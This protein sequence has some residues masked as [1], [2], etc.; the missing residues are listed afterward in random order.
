MPPTHS[1]QAD[2]AAAYRTLIAHETEPK[3]QDFYRTRL[4]RLEPRTEPESDDF[5]TQLDAEFI[6]HARTAVPALVAAVERVQALADDLESRA[7]AIE[8]ANPTHTTQI[9]LHRQHAAM[10]RQALETKP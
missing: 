9:A 7:D 8:E 3:E 6:A 2:V 1:S 5:V 10:I 4:Q